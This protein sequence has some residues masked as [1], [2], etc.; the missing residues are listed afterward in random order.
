ML[1]KVRVR[2]T[3]FCALAMGAILLIMTCICLAVSERGIRE[4]S[5]TDFQTNTASLLSYMRDQTVLSHTWISQME[6]N[7]DI[8]LNILDGET[9]LLYDSL[10]PHGDPE[11]FALARETAR[12]EYHLDPARFDPPQV[13]MRQEVFPLPKTKSGGYYAAVAL[14]PKNGGYL[15]VAALHSTAPV[16]AQLTRQRLLFGCGSLAAWL[17]LT[18][19]AWLFTGRMLLPIEESRKQQI[20]FVASASHELRSP[21]TVMLAS[22]SAARIAEPGER[23]RFFD[24][25]ESEGKR[26]SR[27]IRDMLTLASSD[28]RSWSMHPERVEADT[29]LLEIYEMYE[30]QAS[31]LNLRFEIR[32]PDASVPACL[33]D[34]ERIRQALGV[35][36]DNA[37]AYT[38]P[39]GFVALSLSVSE[40]Y[41]EYAVSDNGPG[42][43]DAQKQKIFERFFR[44]DNARRDREHFGLGLCI[45]RE[46]VLL[47]K[48]KIRVED[49]PGGGATFLI[50]LPLFGGASKKA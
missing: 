2:L 34:R 39:G 10:S 50:R 17:L 19:L 26:M 22:L 25:I 44:A 13:L 14:L 6:Y 29:L 18:L 38:P 31:K 12:R 20:R 45:A 9:P 35:L 33:L 21:L 48:G 41:L 8:V 3:F 11:L 16:L 24:A 23:D 36:I 15:N 40:K 42:I 1:N 7:Y 5:F 49:T 32:L 37:F 47:H 43:E 30:P 27:L 28:S 46:I 4:K